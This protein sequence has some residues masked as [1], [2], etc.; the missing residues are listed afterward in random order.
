[1]NICCS[2]ENL[3]HNPLTRQRSAPTLAR[4]RQGAQLMP[5]AMEASVLAHRTLPP[6]A[7]RNTL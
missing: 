1:M 6:C 7:A 5:V 4:I 2:N 3:R